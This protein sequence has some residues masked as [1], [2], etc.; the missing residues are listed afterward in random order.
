M[1]PLSKPRFFGVSE[2]SLIF[3][4]NLYPD[5][6]EKPSC[7]GMPMFLS[8]KTTFPQQKLLARI[9]LS[10]PLRSPIDGIDRIDGCRQA[11]KSLSN[12]ERLSKRLPRALGAVGERLAEAHP[13]SISGSFHVFD[14]L[15]D[16]RRA[17]RP[18]PPRR[19]SREWFRP[20]VPA[21]FRR[22]R[23][24]PV[25]PPHGSRYIHATS[26]WHRPPDMNPAPP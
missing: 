6:A 17:S 4:R 13:E 8:G 10:L 9:T 24:R 25:P 19:F 26:R 12:R 22:L 18:P 5:C 14:R 1:G 20:R 15:R 16:V 23:S 7:S 11:S 3:C 21:R 2:K